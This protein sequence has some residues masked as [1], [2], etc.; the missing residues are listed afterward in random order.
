[1]TVKQLINVL[2][3]VPQDLPIAIWNDISWQTKDDPHYIKISEC[4]WTHSNYPYDKEDFN[5]INLE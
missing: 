5:Y 3:K 1:M 4:V 2:K